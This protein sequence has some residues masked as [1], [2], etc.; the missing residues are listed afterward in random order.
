MGQYGEPTDDILSA[1]VPMVKGGTLDFSRTGD[2]E[3]ESAT[4]LIRGKLMP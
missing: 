1:I 3:I 4:R 2:A